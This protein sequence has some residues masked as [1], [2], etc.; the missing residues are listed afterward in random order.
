MRDR[1]GLRTRVPVEGVPAESDAVDSRP[2]AKQSVDR[3]IKRT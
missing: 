1:H 3:L 2:A